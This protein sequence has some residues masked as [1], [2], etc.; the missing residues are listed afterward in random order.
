MERHCARPGCSSPAEATL[1]YDYRARTAWV[2]DVAGER[3]PSLY[4]LC[5]R[6]ADDLTVPNGWDHVDRR[7]VARPAFDRS[8]L[9]S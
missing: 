4:D 9:A 6:H 3:H 2:D 8:Q 5:T 1:S 7:V